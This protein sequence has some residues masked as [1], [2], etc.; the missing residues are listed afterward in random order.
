MEKTSDGFVF[1]NDKCI[2]CGR[3]MLECPAPE[4]NLSVYRNG[5]R[6]LLVTPDNCVSCGE[7]F[8]VCSHG[9]RQYRDGTESFL[10]ALKAGEEISLIVSTSFYMTYGER[11]YK[12]L[13]YLR[14]LGVKKIYDAAF[15]AGIFVYLSARFEKEYAGDAHKRPFILNSCPAVTRYIQ[16]YAPE[17]VDY[18]V[19]VQSPPLCTS[20]YARKYLGD[21]AK[22]AYISTC[23]AREA[24]FSLESSQHLIDYSVTIG[25][26]MKC[27]GDV[28][29]E[30]YDT[31]PDLVSSALSSTISASSG[32]RE[33]IASLF[34]DDEIITSYN[35][36]DRRTRGLI[37]STLDKTIPHP[38]IACISACE[39]GCVSG[40]GLDRNA[41]DNYSTYFGSLQKFRRRSMAERRRYAS[42]WELYQSISDM[43]GDIRP[44]DFELKLTHRYI[45]L[46]SV[47]GSVINDIFTRMH[48]TRE[49]QRHVDCHACGY[50]SC[51][52]MAAA[53]AK[54]YARIEDCTRFVTEEFRR[55]LYFD[56]MTGL[57]SSQ[58]FHIEAMMML[59]KNRD[60]KY[61]VC[62]C[63]INGVK[64]IN[65]LYN[66][67]VGSQVIV[68]VAH[69]LSSLVKGIGI[70][71]RLGGNNFVML[72]E[73][74]EENLR[75]MMIM[76]YFDCGEMGIT[77]S[78]SARFGLC[79]VQ[80]MGDIKRIVN[81]A[82]LAMQ[83]TRDRTYNS[84]IWYTDEMR[85][86][87]AVESAI[88]SQMR[89]AMFN[90]EFKMF[91]QPQYN[92]STGALV[93]AETLCRWKKSDGEMI[94]PGVF[95]PIFEKNGFIKKLDRYMW[96]CAFRQVRKWMDENSDPVPISVN[97][98]RMSL[99][100]DDL[101]GVISE[102]LD[103]YKIDPALLHFEITESAYTDD[104][105]ALI[106]RISRIRELGFMIAMDDFG[107]GYS[108]LNT[109]KDIP[110]D[111]LKL[112][113][114]FLRGN[115]NKEKGGNIIGSV[116][117]MAHAIG[118]VTIAEGVET[119]EQADF[120]KSLGC[121]VIQGY[122]YARPMPV[123][124]YEEIMKS[125]NREKQIVRKVDFG[126]RDITEL[127]AAGSE[128]S[129]FFETY[130]GPAGVF[131]YRTG[132]LGILRINDA[133]VNILG[134]SGVPPV[135]YT[136]TFDKFILDKD[137]L[138]VAEAISRAIHGE[139]GTVC[140]FGY[141]RPDGRKIIVRARLWYFGTN[142]EDTILYTIA[143]DVTD[144][145]SYTP[146]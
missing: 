121:D 76:R 42:Y 85:N 78:V 13:G 105:D 1:V 118:L 81:Y 136:Q 62:A 58:G 11:A 59:Q 122:L 10:E 63:N 77:M 94:S 47:P 2:G 52:E 27:L 31:E 51:Y 6:Q 32:L 125:G 102:L 126:K 139:D 135:E 34:S 26:L 12:I 138:G 29:F 117:R 5:Q 55:K 37:A 46:R 79:D 137:R 145:L 107:S 116:I 119:I 44:R 146:V 141:V 24:E 109:L 86:E 110:I 101:I 90:N 16:R 43:Y 140:M 106:S 93:G 95:I 45:Q 96:E 127:L 19:P 9:A 115:S 133:L 71:G 54:G 128:K 74:S 8:D 23:I 61:V 104:Q 40:A 131:C 134:Y 65:D 80:G 67:N 88:T 25:R 98:S 144:V 21:N 22:F 41:R 103:D 17:V 66:F 18:I 83:K 124:Q 97:I 38:F 57:L 111:I 20:I 84:Y 112:D 143:D 91:L 89:K 69:T 36:L 7:C 49:D 92:H 99:V 123:E 3:C 56:D 53:V 35:K 72:F 64:T 70:C 73:K 82:S 113:M 120:L 50:G 114:G 130:M 87:I 33:F 142:D 132:K 14:S 68:Y 39:Y 100:D 48:M 75:R 30:G 60:K 4:T 108:S 129:R 28:D 15:G